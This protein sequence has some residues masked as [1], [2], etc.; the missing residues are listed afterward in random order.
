MPTVFMP[1][2]RQRM[3]LP[4]MS[5][6]M[7]SLISATAKMSVAVAPVVGGGAPPGSLELELLEEPAALF[8]AERH[9]L[10]AI[11]VEQV[12]DD[13]GHRRVPHSSPD[14]GVRGQ[15]HPRL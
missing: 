11:E 14:G 7:S 3:A 10:M 9:R 1:R 12:E 13:V 8:V 2:C 6:L 4:S 5:R 15:V